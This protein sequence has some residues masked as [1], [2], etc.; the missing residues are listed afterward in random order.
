[1]AIEK[2]SPCRS[3]PPGSCLSPFSQGLFPES[4]PVDLA[5]PLVSRCL[6]RR[7][8]MV[9]TVLMQHGLWWRSTVFPFSRTLPIRILFR[10]IVDITV[11]VEATDFRSFCTWPPRASFRRLPHLENDRRI[12]CRGLP[13]LK[14]LT[15]T[16]QIPVSTIELMSVT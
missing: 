8:R 14:G 9:R 1:M 2:E 5:P 10:S 7:E 15:L 13:A 12:C 4:C 16:L 6:Q 11:E 3:Q